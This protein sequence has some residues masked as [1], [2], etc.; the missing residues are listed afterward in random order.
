[1]ENIAKVIDIFL[2]DVLQLGKMEREKRKED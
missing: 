1:L 2:I